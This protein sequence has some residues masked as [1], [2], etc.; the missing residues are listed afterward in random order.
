MDHLLGTVIRRQRRW[1]WEYVTRHRC[2][3]AG[4][5]FVYI[6]TRIG[7]R[8][9]FRLSPQACATGDGGEFASSSTIASLSICIL[10][11]I[12]LP[13]LIDSEPFSS[14]YY[15]GTTRREDS[16]PPGDPIR[17][18][19]GAAARMPSLLLSTNGEMSSHNNLYELGPV[20]GP[21]RQALDLK[22]IN[23]A[24]AGT[25]A[26]LQ[27]FLLLQRDC[28]G[29]QKYPVSSTPETTISA[30][31]SANLCLPLSPGPLVM[32]H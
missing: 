1:S 18:D 3:C 9:S 12:T 30:P 5:V 31:T 27:Q 11:T 6:W 13:S 17:R 26:I 32:P 16:E 29:V 4:N 20:L 14:A 7:A 22:S 19:L 8:N 23:S 21:R 25:L 15:L 28:L 2:T 10:G 24:L